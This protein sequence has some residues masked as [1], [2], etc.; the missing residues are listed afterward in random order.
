MSRQQARLVA[1]AGSSLSLTYNSPEFAPIIDLLYGNAAAAPTAE[2][3]PN[4][5]LLAEN[6]TFTLYRD[7]TRLYRG[8][9]LP[10][11]ADLLLGNSC[12]HLAD[13]SRGGLLFHAGAVARNGCGVIFPGTMGAG[14][15]TL[16][17]WL[18]TRGFDYLSDEFVF[19]ATGSDRIEGLPR[20]LNLKKPSRRV[21]RA[22]LD[23]EAHADEILSTPFIDLVSPKLLRPET[24]FSR[25][26]LSLVIFPNYQARAT[27]RLESLSK[28]QAGKALMQ[29]LINARNLPGHGFDDIARLARHTPAYRMTY[30]NFDQVGNMVKRLV[31]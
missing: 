22:F 6:G 18:L 1:F 26:P 15:T 8:N 30:N 11:L 5:R 2:A 31:E 16:T 13:Q 23:F 27:F 14:K 25:P 28:A 21:L 9:S 4:Y 24:Q 3:Q 12:H 10:T 7:E 20:P 17:A 19:V 29:C